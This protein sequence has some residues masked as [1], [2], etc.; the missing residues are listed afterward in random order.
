MIL[1]RFHW[2]KALQ[3]QREMKKEHFTERK[4]TLNLIDDTTYLNNNWF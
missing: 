4:I 1:T 2:N 3:L